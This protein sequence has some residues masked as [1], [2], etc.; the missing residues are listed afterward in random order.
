MEQKQLDEIDESYFGEEF[1]DDEE[2][3]IL[4][5]VK[6]ER[7]RVT[8]YA[9]DEIK[10]EAVTPRRKMEKLAKRKTVKK[11]AEKTQMKHESKENFKVNVTDNSSKDM[12]KKAS[13]VKMDSFVE[14]KK[15]MPVKEAKPVDLKHETKTVPE[16]V[17]YHE[18]AKKPIETAPKFDPW[19]DDSADNPSFFKET[20]TW[21]AITGIILVLL[22]FSVFT[23]G[24]RFA[25]ESSPLTGA[26]VSI[27]DAEQMAV[28]YVNSYLL[29]PPFY[30]EI[31]N[32]EE[33]G[34]FYKFTFS[35]AGDLFESYVTKDGEML[36]PQGF[37][38][39]KTPEEQLPYVTSSE[40]FT[41]VTEEPVTEEPVVAETEPIVEVAEE[42][43][44]TGNLHEET[45]TAKKWLFSPH[46]VTVTQGDTVRLTIVPQNMEFTFAIP[47]MDIEEEVSGRTTVEFVATHT[48]SYEFICESC[49]DFRGMNGLIV[50]K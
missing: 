44:T 12:H 24:F 37:N 20:S 3:D 45:I 49:E 32:R 26:V 47:T 46:V 23:Q 17:V 22:V 7:S 36:F 15:E 27:T 33:T 40:E 11:T 28:R 43:V 18:P 50:V 35:V 10:I 2:F 16:T 31:V 25:E 38:T 34:E 39:A 6:P 5:E 29:Q 41:E 4:A 42:P 48:G 9:D 13:S 30:A 19:D 1:I 21:K 14:T 8:D